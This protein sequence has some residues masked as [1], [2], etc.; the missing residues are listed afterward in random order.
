MTAD[1]WRTVALGLGL[2]SISSGVGF[3]LG[4]ALGAPAAPRLAYAAVAGSVLTALAIELFRA[5][6]RREAVA[7]VYEDEERRSAID[8]VNEDLARERA[9]RL[10]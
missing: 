9:R 8:R 10:P 6:L 1:A 2:F 3:M 7:R 5:V 4:L